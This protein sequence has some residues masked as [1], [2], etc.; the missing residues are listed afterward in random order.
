[1]QLKLRQLI[2]F[3]L[4]CAILIYSQLPAGSLLAMA[5][6]MQ[7]MILVQSFEYSRRS[8]IAVAKLYL[9]SIPSF[10]FWGGARS[11]VSIYFFEQQYVLFLMS[12]VITF[13]LSFLIAIQSINSFLL[14]EANNFNVLKSIQSSFNSVKKNIKNLSKISVLIFIFSLI[15]IPGADWKL[16]FAVAATHLYLNWV[17]VKKVI[18]PF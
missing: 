14:L 10:F 15:P 13:S 7:L 6:L 18:G 11:F 8:Q 9:F 1:M 2:L 16:I 12:C 3:I 5:V 17:Q 4:A